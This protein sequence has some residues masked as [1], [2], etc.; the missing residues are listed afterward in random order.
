MAKRLTVTGSTMRRSPF[1]RKVALAQELQKDVWPLFGAGKAR[2]VIDSTFK[3][4]D[5][6]AAHRRMETS[7]HIG[8]IL[9]EVRGG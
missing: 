1:A 5:A 7:Q 3:L 9:L 2:V 6:A 4:A 8:K